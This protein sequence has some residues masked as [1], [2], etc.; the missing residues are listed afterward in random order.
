MWLRTK[1]DSNP[2]CIELK[3]AIDADTVQG[4]HFI[5]LLVAEYIGNQII[6]KYLKYFEIVSTVFRNVKLNSSELE[7]FGILRIRFGISLEFRFDSLFVQS[8]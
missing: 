6:E 5:R 3:I 1:K 7:D 4:R 2:S 8:E